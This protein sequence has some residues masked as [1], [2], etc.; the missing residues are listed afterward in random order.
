MLNAPPAR[1][2]GKRNF[3]KKK[4]CKPGLAD[5]VSRLSTRMLGM[6]GRAASA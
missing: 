3:A 1:M 4:S 2:S 6:Y 5:R